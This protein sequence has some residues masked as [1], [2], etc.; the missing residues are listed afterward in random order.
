MTDWNAMSDEEF[1]AYVRKFLEE[2][3]PEHLRHPP[4]RLRWKDVSEWYLLRARQGWTAP[5]WPAEFGGVGLSP[6][7]QLIY[8]EEQERWGVARAPD[9]GLATVG[10]LL[11]RYG[12]D[13]Q[14]RDYLPK[15]LS[16]EHIWCQG[17]SEPNAGSDL[18]SLRVEAVDD[19]DAWIVTGQKT[20]TTLA[21]DATHMFLLARTDLNAKRKQEGISFLLLDMKT[22]GVTVRPIRNI[23]DHEEFCEVFLD[24]VRIPKNNL[25]GELHQGWTM[26]KALLGFERLFLGSPKNSQHALG[27]LERFAAARGLY[28][29]PVFVDQLT[30]LQLDV[31][32]LCEAYEGFAAQV[33]AGKP[34]GADISWLK[35]WGTETFNRIAA[36]AVQAG[37]PEAALADGVDAEGETVDLLSLYFG[38]LPTTIYGG[39]NEIQRDILAKQV[40]RLPE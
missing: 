5:G 37:G 18:A 6:A 27:R 1:R 28:E 14:R 29:D 22:P 35:L 7:K 34:L 3:Y 40:L 21:Q 33:R 10:P 17:Y 20:W 8:I 2:N 30:R 23:A 9:Q 12:T 11:I 26:A 13:E 31:A 32:D 19:G 16:W 39:T 25:V 36:L 4:R 24:H 38:A 15:I